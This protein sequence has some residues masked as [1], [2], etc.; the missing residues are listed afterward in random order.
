MMSHKQSSKFVQI[1][2]TAF[3]YTVL[4]AT[5]SAGMIDLGNGAIYDGKTNTI[6]VRH[7]S[8]DTKEEIWKSISSFT[9]L[10]NLEIDGSSFLPLSDIKKLSTLTNLQ[11]LE[12]DGSSFLTLSNIEKLSTLADLKRLTI[13]NFLDVNKIKELMWCSRLKSLTLGGF[14]KEDLETLKAW[15]PNTTITSLEDKTRLLKD[16]EGDSFNTIISLEPK[17]LSVNFT[18]SEKEKFGGDLSHRNFPY[19]YLPSY[20]ELYGETTNNN[21]DKEENQFMKDLNE[22]FP[23]KNLDKQDVKKFSPPYTQTEWIPWEN[24]TLYDLNTYTL[25]AEKITS[26][27]KKL[28]LETIQSLSYLQ[29]LIIDGNNVLK[30]E[31]L[32]AFSSL[33]NLQTLRLKN[34]VSPKDFCFMDLSCFAHL[35]CLTLVNFN[36]QWLEVVKDKLPKTKIIIIEG[37]EDFNR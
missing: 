31:D 33:Q 3:L 8:E 20:K 15:L 32:Y 22:A 24:D 26:E 9:D 16:L 25:K 2:S 18:N 30:S 19:E 14:Q 36:P 10:K 28:V 4:L 12:I 5:P 17:D 13:Y 1:I 7:V 23:Y 29:H 27:N 34:L 21:F 6:K 35:E 37:N 11:H